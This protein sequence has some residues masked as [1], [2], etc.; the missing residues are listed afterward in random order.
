M[1]YLRAE[2]TFYPVKVVV[3]ITSFHQ[4]SAPGSQLCNYPCSLIHE[5]LFLFIR[6]MNKN[7]G[8]KQDP[9]IKNNFIALFNQLEKIGFV[10]PLQ[11]K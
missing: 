2:L 11:T 5:K 3:Q 6:S 4:V 1:T 10:N 8:L 7:H 9:D